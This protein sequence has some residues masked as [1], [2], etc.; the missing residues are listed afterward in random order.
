[1]EKKH[2][3]LTAMAVVLTVVCQAQQ[4]PERIAGMNEFYQGQETQRLNPDVTITPGT[5]TPT[6]VQATFTPNAA[7]KSY[8][9]LMSTASEMQSWSLMMG[10]PVD[11][12]VAQWG[13]T[14]SGVQTYTWTEMIPNT[15]Y[16]VYAL[17]KDS[18]GQASPLVTILATTTQN[19]GSG[20]ST[21]TVVVNDITSTQARVVV[22]PNAE[23]AVFHDGL[24]TVDYYN[25]IGS[26][27]ALTLIKSNPYPLYTTDDWIWSDLTP[28]TDYYAIGIGQNADS[29]WGTPAITP[30]TTLSSAGIASGDA[31]ASSALIYPV[32]TTGIFYFQA[33]PAASGEIRIIDLNGKTVFSQRITPARTEINAS[34]LGN[35]CYYLRYWPDSGQTPVTTKLIIAK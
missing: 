14:Y 33:D 3:F 35:G 17:P 5:I 11:S 34:S 8:D 30:F 15:E 13:I 26:D 27:S 4:L 9:I 20:L 31:T 6:T 32:P 19:G 12:L 18:L 10:V 25:T 16:T 1:M 23:T 21:L 2:S 29:I 22:T 28:A 7:C 24:I